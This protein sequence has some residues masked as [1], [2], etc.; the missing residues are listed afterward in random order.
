[1][2]TFAEGFFGAIAKHAQKHNWK[3]GAIDEASK[4]A[5]ALLTHTD[6]ELPKINPGLEKVVR[7]KFTYGLALS[8]RNMPNVMNQ[9]YFL[10]MRQD[11]FDELYQLKL[12]Q[13]H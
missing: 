5:E 13:V 8:H 3:P 7:D 9:Q 2:H 11:W 4:Y 1:V 10:G 6:K 12:T